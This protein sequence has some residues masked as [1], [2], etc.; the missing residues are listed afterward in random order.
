MKRLL[1]FLPLFLIGCCYQDKVVWDALD[2]NWKLMRPYVV[3]GIQN[4]ASIEPESKE[5]RLKNVTDLDALIAEGL[6]NAK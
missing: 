6:K 1:V 2:S 5:L 4:D 3:S